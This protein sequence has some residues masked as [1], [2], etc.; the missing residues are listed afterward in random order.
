MAVSFLTG[1]YYIF[2]DHTISNDYISYILVII[3]LIYL[4]ALKFKSLFLM[5]IILLM[6]IL[7]PLYL[8]IVK[9]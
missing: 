4:L 7:L 5:W 2:T 3:S 6:Q 8:S 9:T 1:V